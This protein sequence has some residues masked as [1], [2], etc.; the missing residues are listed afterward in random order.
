MHDFFN[1]FQIST[2]FSLSLASLSLAIAAA[3]IS[4]LLM[5]IA[6]RFAVDRMKKSPSKLPAA[7][8]TRWSR[9][10]AAATTG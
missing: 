3:L 1:W 4:Y 2:I 9:C 6:L 7:S 8:M 10:S 5:R